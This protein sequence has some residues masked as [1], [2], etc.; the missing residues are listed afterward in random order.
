M[1]I[2]KASCPAERVRLLTSVSTLAE[3]SLLSCSYLESFAQSS[4]ASG[5][6]H[7]RSP[8]GEFRDLGHWLKVVEKQQI[9][10]LRSPSAHFAQDDNALNAGPCTSPFGLR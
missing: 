1:S 5:L 8:I 6:P 10:R 4:Y 3:Q 9:L 2:T 7:L